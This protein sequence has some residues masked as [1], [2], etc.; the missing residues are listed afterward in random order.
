MLEPILCSFIWAH[1]IEHPVFNPYVRENSIDALKARVKPVLNLSEEELIKLIPNRSGFIFVGCPNCDEGTQEGELSWNITDPEHVFC[2][3]C[4]MCFPNETFLDTNILKATNPLGEI[5]DY[6]YWED[7]SGYR[8]FFQA[9]GWYVAR[10]YFSSIAYDLAML[11]HLTNESQYARRAALI[12]DRFAQVYPGYC[13]T[14]DYPGK[15]KSLFERNEPPYPYWGGKWSRWFYGDIPTNL[16]LAYDVIYNSGELEKLSAEQGADVKKR[17]EDNLFHA[18]VEFV[19]TYPIQLG[20]MDPTIH[21]GLIA[22]GRVLGEPGYVHDAVNRITQLFIRRFF[23]D[24]SWKEGA[25]SYHNQTIGGLRSAITLLKGYSDPEDYTYPQDGMHFENLD[26]EA[27]FPV[28][29]KAINIPELLKYPNGR[30]VPIHDTWAKESR[31]PT[32]QAGSMLLPA[33][34][35]ARLGRGEGDNQMQVHLHFSGGYGHQHNDALS[36][37]LFAKERELLSDI[38]YTHTR[39]RRW[40]TSTLAHNTVMVDGVEQNSGSETQPSDGNLLM[41]VPGDDVIQAIEVSGEHAYPDRVQT[42]RRMLILVEVSPEDAYIVDIFRVVGG[43]RHEYVLHGDADYDSLIETDLSLTDYGENLLPAGT[44]VRLP[45]RES[46]SGDAGEHNIAYT[47]VRD[48]KRTQPSKVWT[49]TFKSEYKDNSETCSH[50]RVHGLPESGTELFFGVTPSI[51]RADEND[52]KLDD[53]T[54]PILVARR[55][56]ENLDSTFVS[57]FEPHSGKPFLKSVERLETNGSSITLKITHGDTTDFILL[58]PNDSI[59]SELKV[60]ALTLRG[61]LGF[62]REINGKIDHMRLI[63]GT[64]LSKGDCVLKSDGLIEG[65]VLNVL[66]KAKGDALNGFVV[67]MDTLPSEKLADATLINLHPDGFTYGYKIKDMVK[68]EGRTIIE[69]TDDPGYE[70][71]DGKTRLVFF[72]QRESKGENTFLVHLKN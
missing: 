7:E 5:Q 17:I 14:N 39:Y 31:S 68:I 12:L 51:R 2:R 37:M 10:N 47:F 36:I 22:V 26:L 46:D 58:S 15:Q 24:G 70:I 45:I 40:A 33:M 65:K 32:N 44:S 54:M 50:L 55:E 11:Y 9:K 61:K 23:F 16:V 62:V 27:E 8:Y 49:A 43:N 18:A 41:Y 53:I 69:L 13:V 3:Y 71:D 30:T 35:H 20:N 48:V 25:V 21:R 57:V 4:Q 19:R 38:G 67:D 72:P 66:R 52:A 63:G 64:H 60:D 42:Y 1:S 6:P 29:Q 56:D 59:D 34:G 28:I